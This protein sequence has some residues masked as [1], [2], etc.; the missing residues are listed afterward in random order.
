MSRIWTEVEAE[1]VGSPMGHWAEMTSNP[2]RVGLLRHGPSYLGLRKDN[3]AACVARSKAR[4]VS[5]A[6]DLMSRSRQ[7][8]L[9]LTRLT[10]LQLG[11]AGVQPSTVGK[12]LGSWSTCACSI[13]RPLTADVVQPGCRAPS[14]VGWQLG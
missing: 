7:E 9:W 14:R 5:P 12:E 13:A 8:G 6:E 1:Q 4:I 11:F 3:R 2:P 10:D